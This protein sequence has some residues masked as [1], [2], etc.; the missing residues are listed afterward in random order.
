MLHP[1][2]DTRFVQAVVVGDG[3]VRI[4]GT[5]ESGLGDGPGNIAAG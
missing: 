2:R 4:S 5:P 1:V 3:I